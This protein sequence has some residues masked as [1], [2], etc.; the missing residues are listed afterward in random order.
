MENDI[1]AS[2]YER[3]FAEIASQLMVCSETVRRTVS[4]FLNTGDVKPCNIGRPTGSISLIPHEEYIIMDCVFRM[5]QIQLHEITNH[6][7]N[8]GAVHR[9]GMTRIKVIVGMI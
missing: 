8:V 4:T 9:L 3:S 7:L 1:S 2:I 5:P 6:V